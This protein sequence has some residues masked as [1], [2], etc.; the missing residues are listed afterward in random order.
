[1]DKEIAKMWA[2]ALRSKEYKQGY[3]DLATPNGKFCALGVL[4]DLLITNGIVPSYRWSIDNSDFIGPIY[5]EHNRTG[6]DYSA[7]IPSTIRHQIGMDLA[8]ER[9][10]TRKN[11]RDRM[12]FERI[13]NYIDEHHGRP[14]S[15]FRK[16]FDF[17]FNH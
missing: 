16:L 8:F 4:V 10:I 14:V 1:M 2:D 7:V 9:A 17:I 13:A 6:V 11:D 15:K 5:L 12:S 3:F